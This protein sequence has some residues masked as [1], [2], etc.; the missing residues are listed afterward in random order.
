MAEFYCIVNGSKINLDEAQNI[1][2]D[3]FSL[4]AKM[5][6][7]LKLYKRFPNRQTEL[8]DD[9]TEKAMIDETTSQPMVESSQSNR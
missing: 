7:P 4:H 1:G 5:N 6:M 8:I 2:Y 3:E 9:K